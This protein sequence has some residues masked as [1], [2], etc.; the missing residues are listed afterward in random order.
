VRNTVDH[1]TVDDLLTFS[2]MVGLISLMLYALTADRLVRMLH[3]E[4]W[5][6]W[7]DLG[8][9]VGIFYI[10]QDAKWWHGMGAHLGLVCDVLVKT[11][12]W[13]AEKP[14][15]MFLIKKV[16]WCIALAVLS[17]IAGFVLQRLSSY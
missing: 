16:R 14:E 6:A 12:A 5:E 2:S 10:P 3:E 1:N 17:I 13:F 11:P 4:Y 15:L 7:A 9:P 8:R